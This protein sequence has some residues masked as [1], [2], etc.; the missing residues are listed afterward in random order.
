MTYRS[1]H[2]TLAI[3]R[4]G[5]AIVLVQQQDETDSAPVWLLPGGLVE[6]GELMVD[7]L[8]REV[9]EEAG[10]AVQVID[11]LA[12]LSQVERTAKAAQAFAYIFESHCWEGTLQQ[13]D[14]DG[15]IVSVDLI[16]L[17][18]ACEKLQ[19]SPSWRAIRE[20]LLAYL[21]GEVPA[22]AAWCYREEGGEQ[23]KQWCVYPS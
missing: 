15:E 22:G 10:V 20:P 19:H 17:S 4:R 2:I 9:R 16:A 8:I 3:L 7:A 13:N 1:D 5:D 23:H 14:P 11:R 6:P 12:V 21:R 18:E